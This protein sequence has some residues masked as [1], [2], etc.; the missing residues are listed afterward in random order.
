MKT[1]ALLVTLSALVFPLA[2]GCGDSTASAASMPGGA[3]AMSIF[4]TRCVGCHGNDGRGDGAAA[5]ALNPR[6]RNFRESS[7]QDATS[8]AAIERIIV[9]GGAA[10]GKAPGMPPNPDLRAKPEVV[11]ALRAHIRSLRD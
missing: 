10:V 4:T 5:A 8:D 3:E 9:E 7:W 2:A 1:N 6:P 11:A